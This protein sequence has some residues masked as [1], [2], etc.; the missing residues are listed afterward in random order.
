[1]NFKKLVIYCFC[2]SITLS[3]RV[4][5]DEEDEPDCVRATVPFTARPQAL[6]RAKYSAGRY[7]IPQ[8]FIF[9]TLFI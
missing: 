1:M 2:V 4:D 3:I 9:C 6:R 7:T 5:L 8:L